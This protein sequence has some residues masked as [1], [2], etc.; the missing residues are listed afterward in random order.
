MKGEKLVSWIQNGYEKARFGGIELATVVQTEPELNI[1][2][3]GMEHSLNA[4]F[5]VIPKRFV[6]DSIELTGVW[7]ITAETVTSQTQ[8][9]SDH[10]HTINPIPVEQ[11]EMDAAPAQIKSVLKIG[12]RLAVMPAIGGRR[13]MILD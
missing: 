8:T 11:I 7:P 9:S 1:K 12:D 13:Y 4:S 5:L 3:D 10:S 2:I 6:N